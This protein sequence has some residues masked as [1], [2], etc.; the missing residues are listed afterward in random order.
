MVH[1][2]FSACPCV[3]IVS[4]GPSPMASKDIDVVSVERKESST[5]QLE[6]S[7]VEEDPAAS[8]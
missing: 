4:P 8:A 7:L 5:K 2:K 6:A 1:I 3:S